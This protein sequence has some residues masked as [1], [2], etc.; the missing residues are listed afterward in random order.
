[1][2]PHQVSIYAPDLGH[3]PSPFD[4]LGMGAGGEVGRRDP[5]LPGK[6]L[7]T[8]KPSEYKR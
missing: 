6:R 3:A 2:T 5:N 7:M 4:M 1:M 8:V